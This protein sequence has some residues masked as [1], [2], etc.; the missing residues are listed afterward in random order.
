MSA[1]DEPV[2]LRDGALGDPMF[3]AAI[4]MMEAMREATTPILERFPDPRDGLSALMAAAAMFAGAQAGHLIAG[5]AL[6][7]R[8]RK[9]VI[10]AITR[11]ARQGIDVGISRGG[12]A[13]DG[14][15]EGTA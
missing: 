1:S 12:R 4:E 6:Q 15:V 13:W 10:E 8:D 5:G 9:R 14:I 2:E 3:N 7:L 11:N